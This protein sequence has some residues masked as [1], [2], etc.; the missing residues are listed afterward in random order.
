MK[1]KVILT[2]LIL[3]IALIPLS[4]GMTSV[5]TYN[6]LN[7]SSL[8]NS[9]QEDDSQ[10]FNNTIDD[11]ITQIMLAGHITSLS[12]SVVYKDSIIWS[13]GYG[14]QSDDNIAFL[15]ASIT[16]TLTATAILQLYEQGLIDLDEDV[17]DFLPFSLRNPSYPDKPITFRHLLL[18][19]SSLRRGG[20]FYQTFVFNDLD[21]KLGLTNETLPSFPAWLDDVILSP[22]S[23]TNS[24]L[25]GTWAPGEKQGNLAYSNLGYD[26][27]GYLVELVSNQ[28]IEEYF[29]SNI[30]NP[31]NMTRTHYTYQ[32]YSSDE[33]ASAIEW[34]PNEYNEF[35]FSTDEEDNL[36]IP[37]FNLD[38]LGAGALRSTTTDLS[39]FLIAHMNNGVY[40]N[41]RILLAESI[42][43]MHNTSQVFYGIYNYDSYGFG[44]I[45][46][47]INTVE[48]D[49]EYYSQPLQGHGGRT[50]GFNSLMFFNQDVKLGMILFINQGF[51]FVPEF[52]NQWEIFDLLYKEGLRFSL[53]YSSSENTSGFS[54]F[55]LSLTIV[56]HVIAIKFRKYKGN[57][58]EVDFL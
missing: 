36:N 1:K 18:H 57:R 3:I 29:Q 7:Y 50:Y 58:S 28:T 32:S 4:N 54:F 31:L 41:N 2:S 21:Q 42:N 55:L 27:L 51:N 53:S 25:W 11:T 30:F 19:Q 6:D 23:Q 15:I 13:K 14:E 12:A 46:S 20:E 38:E 37:H 45:N 49:G 24:D 47:K 34:I 39:H 52:D 33:L 10:T 8:A 48:L 56:L 5:L 17:N 9:L 35:N 43:L 40:K 22:E 16:K 26:L 44:W